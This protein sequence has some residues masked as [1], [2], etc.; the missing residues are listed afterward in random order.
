V[1]IDRCPAAA[2]SRKNPLA[3]RPTVQRSADLAGARA[4]RLQ[5]V[6]IV[7]YC[8]FSTLAGR[9]GN[10]TRPPG[11]A[12]RNSITSSASI[13]CQRHSSSSSSQVSSQK[14]ARPNAS[15][16]LDWTLSRYT[17]PVLLLLLLLL[18]CI[19]C[20]ECK[21]AHIVVDVP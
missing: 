20:T 11:R 19:V 12:L 7:V 4:C 8:Q 18:G 15:V 14:G 17:N 16:S 2:T 10:A 13:S 9:R 1:R 6:I 3:N 5:P 21:G